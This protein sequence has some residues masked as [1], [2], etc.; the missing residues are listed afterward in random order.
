MIVAFTR[1]TLLPW[2]TTR[3]DQGRASPLVTLPAAQ[4]EVMSA[5][6]LKA[7]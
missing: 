1:H 3:R 6:E 4:R 7:P 5:K 2:T